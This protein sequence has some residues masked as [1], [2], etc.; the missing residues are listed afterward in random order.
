VSWLATTL[1]DGV[2]AFLA[3]SKRERKKIAAVI[4]RFHVHNLN[5]WQWQKWI[6]GPSGNPGVDAQRRCICSL[7]GQDSITAT[8]KRFQTEINLIRTVSK[9]DLKKTSPRFELLVRTQMRTSLG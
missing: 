5:Q 1:R 8:W 9:N 2:T 3:L 6:E 4:E 7:I